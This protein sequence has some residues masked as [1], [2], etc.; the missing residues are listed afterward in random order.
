M[1]RMTNL[2]PPPRADEQA[3]QALAT[4][5]LANLSAFQSFARG[6]LRDEQLA[7]DAVQESL[8][9]ALKSDTNI[10]GDEN[11]VRWFYAFFAT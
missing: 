4:T 8:L 1:G 11:I 6:R 9:R 2:M 5:L 3:E 10:A 7:A